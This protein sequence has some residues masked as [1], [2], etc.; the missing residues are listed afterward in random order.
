MKRDNNGSPDASGKELITHSTPVC[1]TLQVL[2][3]GPDQIIQADFCFAQLGAAEARKGRQMINQFAHLHGRFNDCL[4][5]APA[6]LIEVIV[7][8]S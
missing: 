5:M 1:V 8:F 2:A 4:E 6:L 7:G 3:G